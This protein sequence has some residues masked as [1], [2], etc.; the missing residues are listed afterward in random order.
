MRVQQKLL[1]SRDS[2][3]IISHPT[4]H[5]FFCE[6]HHL[7][8]INLLMYSCIK[9]YLYY[10]YILIYVR[11]GNVF[12]MSLQASQSANTRKLWQYTRSI[13]SCCSKDEGWHWLMYPSWKFRY[14]RIIR[15]L[16]H[17]SMT[18]DIDWCTWILHNPQRFWNLSPKTPPKTDIWSPCRVQGKS[19]SVRC[20]VCK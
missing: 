11:Q 8:H 3:R 9:I 19:V 4:N 16:C 20:S 2:W 15:A 12:P 7:H 17:P 6:T 10:I 1:I 18:Y 5:V 14:F 13:S